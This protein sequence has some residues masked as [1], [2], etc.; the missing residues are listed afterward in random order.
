[1]GLSKCYHMSDYILKSSVVPPVCP[2][3]P[4]TNCPISVNENILRPDK[5]LIENDIKKQNEDKVNCNDVQ[6]NQH[7]SKVYFFLICI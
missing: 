4:T 3:C 1:M 2:A 7:L 5:N 6:I